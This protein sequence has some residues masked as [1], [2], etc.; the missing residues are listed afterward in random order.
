[1]VRSL[2]IPLTDQF[3]WEK[4]LEVVSQS[5]ILKE[6]FK[7][8]VLQTKYQSDDE[9]NRQL[10]GE[11]SKTNRLMKELRQVQSF[12]ADVETT[13]LLKRYDLEVYEKIKSNNHDSRPEN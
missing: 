6:G 2:N 1:M 9:N 12:I 13:N 5:S 11:K 7:T 8:E 10:R 4:V 3:V